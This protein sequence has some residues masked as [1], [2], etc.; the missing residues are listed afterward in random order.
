MLFPLLPQPP[1][2]AGS[3][4]APTFR[5]RAVRELL[6][7]RDPR[8]SVRYQRLAP[9]HLRDAMQ[10]LERAAEPVTE[11]APASALNKR[12]KSWIWSGV[13]ISHG[14]PRRASLANITR[15]CSTASG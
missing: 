1:F 6:G 8:M 10:A 15:Q 14:V 9:G 12:T 4:D 13:S 7:H 3:H 11:S 5:Q 2:P